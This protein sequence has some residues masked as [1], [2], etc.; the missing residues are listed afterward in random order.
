[1]ALALPLV[2]IAQA[3]AAKQASPFGFMVENAGIRM[4]VDTEAA[5]Y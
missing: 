2:L 5:R 4:M 3:G 1:V